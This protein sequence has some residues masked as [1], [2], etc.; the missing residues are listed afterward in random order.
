MAKPKNNILF[1]LPQLSTGG[2]EKVVFELAKK[3]EEHF[4]KTYVVAFRQGELEKEFK[5]T[6]HGVYIVPKRNGIDSK[7]M[8]KIANIIKNKNIQI[9][10]AH[11]YMP[12]FYSYLGSRIFNVRKFIYTEHSVAEVELIHGIYKHILNIMLNRNT[13]IV[14]VSNEITDSFNKMFPEKKKKFYSIP[15]GIDIEKFANHGNRNEVLKSLNLSKNNIVIGNVANFRKIKNHSCLIKAFNILAKRVSDARLVI[16][17]SGF[18]GDLENSEETCRKLIKSYGIES[19]V[20]LTGYI[21]D[22]PRILSGFDIFCLSSFSE[23]LPVSIL[24]AMAAKLPVVASNVRGI[25]EVVFHN[26]TGLLFP[27]DDTLALANTF[28]RLISDINLRHRIINNAFD[29]VIKNH[30]LKGWIKKYLD[31]FDY[32]D[33]VADKL[34]LN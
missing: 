10:N 9:V 19:K 27:S 4:I 32:N 1:V 31:L 33:K 21:E 17:G 18:H 13:Y 22:I 12:F 23:G 28:E 14:G 15:N 16:V 20:R 24:E 26:Q 7:T 34:R 6:C 29:W 11:H 25:K 8:L 30:A 3:F 5:N 2:T